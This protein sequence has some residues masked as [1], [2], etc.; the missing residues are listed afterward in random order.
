MDELVPREALNAWRSLLQAHATVI[1]EIEADLEERGLVPLEWYDLLIAIQSAPDHRLRM[2]DVADT[3]VL[4][5]SNA[6][7]LVDRL[8]TSDLMRR[9]RLDT[10]RRGAVAVLTAKG[11]H[12]L[13]RA[14]PTYARGINRYFVDRLAAD[15]LTTIDQALT[16]VQA[17]TRRARPAPRRR[18]SRSLS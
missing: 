5:R 14:W 13:R 4:T 18:R 6:T 17:A 12:A 3:L 11:R 2:R 7:R 9:E 8:E 10:D 15:E 16:R 1:R